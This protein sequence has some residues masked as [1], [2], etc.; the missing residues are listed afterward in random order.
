MKKALFIFLFTLLANTITYSQTYRLSGTVKAIETGETLIGA[1]IVLK[2]GVGT[3]T[4]FDGRFSI[5]IAAGTYNVSVTYVGFEGKEQKI[6][7]NKDRI[8]EF[9]LS[10]IMI[11]EISVVADVAIARETPVAFTN[12]LPAKIEEELAGQDI[13]MILNSTPGVYATQQGGGDG[14]ARITIRGFSQTNVA[15]MLDGIPVNDM[16]NGWV[17]WSNW[18][19]LNQVTRT[20]QVQRG[21][22]ASKL[23]LPSVGGTMN[24]LTKGIE[25]KRRFEFKQELSSEGKST[26]SLAYNSGKLPGDWGVT[27]A[28]SRKQG[29][30]WVD[31]TWSDAYFYYGKIEKRLGDHIVSF[32]TYG[33]PQSHG[34]RAYKRAIATYDSTYAV[35]VAGVT[36]FPSYL[37]TGGD[38]V[39]YVDKGITYNQQWGY[40]ERFRLI[41]TDSMYIPNKDIW[42]PTAYD[43]VHANRE[44]VHLKENIYYKPMYSLRDFWTVNDK[45]YISNILYLSTGRGGGTDVRNSLKDNNL[46]E[47]GQINWQEIYNAN[48]DI[49]QSG[50]AA[51]SLTERKAGNYR[52]LRRN[53]HFW[54][55]LLSTFNYKK[56]DLLEFSGGIDLR[57]YKGSHQQEVYDLMGADYAITENENVENKMVREG[58]NI[59]YKDDEWVRWGGLFGQVEFNTGIYSTFLNI[60][61]AYT[62][63]QKEDYFKLPGDSLRKTD[64]LWKPSYTLKWGF[65]YNL[66]E[67]ANVFINTGYLS[68]ARPSDYIYQGYNAS[69]RENT[70]NEIVQA[71]ELGYTFTSRKF[72]INLNSYYTRW[73][74]RAMNSISTKDGDVDLYMEVPG[75]DALHKGIEMDFIYKIHPQLEFQG[76]V[77]IGD[78]RWTSEV[79]DVPRYNRN[80]GVFYDYFDFDA[81]GVHV[82]DAAQTQY[83][84]SIRYEPTKSLY[85]MLKTTAFDRYY[86]QMEPTSLTGTGNAIDED[87]NP[88]DSWKAPNYTLFDF[89]TGYT[90]QF[91]S[92]QRI[93]FTF[94]MLNL[95][96]ELYITDAQNND[97]YIYS[98]SPNNFD[99]NSAS[100]YFGMGRRFMAA[101]KFSF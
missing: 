57:S 95:L 12:V 22:G 79:K 1:N 19:G 62:G 52:V 97:R 53:E 66:T 65:N 77:S 36:K 73:L 41:T 76:L 38:T 46:N 31:E 88:R 47:N 69:F 21:L 25:Q 71:V 59:F 45:L 23:A 100:V 37:P 72:A 63:F 3:V 15:V 89:H 16:E 64:W 84:A 24:I 51:Y 93:T 70:D 9:N 75:I 96:D 35:D 2:P 10:S 17:Y 56:S 68:K 54:Y 39:L 49:L 55:G 5:E 4:D 18:F 33:A 43:T 28:F 80:T 40:L 67:R 86:A 81:T 90:W 91:D 94:S 101:V 29:D 48:V 74:N 34:Q 78:W 6:N 85:L 98:T 82:S 99:A 87:G 83:A 13:P 20:I 44:K 58:G 30:G 92:N 14:D 26:Q 27:M 8:V 7:L 42:L 50:D 32:S 60:S 11:D 61:G